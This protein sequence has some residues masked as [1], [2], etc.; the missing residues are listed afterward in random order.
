MIVFF[1]ILNQYSVH[2]NNSKVHLVITA[3]NKAR[4]IK[5]NL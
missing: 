1:Y 3:Y 5:I 4:A 2:K